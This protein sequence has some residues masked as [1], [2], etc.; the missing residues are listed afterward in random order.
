ME[1]EK[2]IRKQK[3]SNNIFITTMLLL[4]FLL[5]IIVFLSGKTQFIFLL[6]LIIL[7]LLIVLG[8]IANINNGALWFVCN[9]NRLKIK[10]G[11]F[12]N[13]NLV[14]CDKVVL[15]HTEHCKE[16]MEIIV[17]T[18][19]KVRN[20]YMKPIIEKNFLRKYPNVEAYYKKIRKV[21]SNN[22]YYYTAIKKGGLI[23]YKLLNVIYV[24][25]VKASF[26]DDAIENIKI[27]RGQ[28]KI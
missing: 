9:N 7:E 17:V 11:T 1:I 23:K 3:Q 26:T 12:R 13:E 4:F 15:V 2:A 27:S 16:D 6:A 18:T 28:K 8:I 22:I 20:K 10:T 21:S 19:V 25:C 5:P 24:N 14:L